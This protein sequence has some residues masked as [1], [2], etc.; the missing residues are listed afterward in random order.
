MDNVCFKF[1]YGI[2][3]IFTYGYGKECKERRKIGFNWK[4]DITD[5]EVDRKIDI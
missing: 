4:I 5:R 2:Y 1:I 3:G